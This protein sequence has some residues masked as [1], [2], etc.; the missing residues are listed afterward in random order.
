MEVS[1]SRTFVKSTRAT[2]MAVL[3]PK[4]LDPE[5]R[6][7]HEGWPRTSMI[8]YGQYYASPQEVNIVP[9]SFLT[10]LATVQGVKHATCR[11]TSFSPLRATSAANSQNEFNRELGCKHNRARDV[12]HVDRRAASSHWAIQFTLYPKV[13]LR[14]TSQE[15]VCPR[16]QTP[17]HAYRI[18]V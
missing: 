3:V 17:A 16:C 18:W 15:S 2:P 8:W 7:L 9:L 14:M 6:V 5:F 4:Q 12:L 11:T 1:Y 10:R 13:A